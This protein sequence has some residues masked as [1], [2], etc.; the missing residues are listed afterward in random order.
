M[1]NRIKTILHVTCSR[2]GIF[3][4]FPSCAILSSSCY[5]FCPLNYL[6]HRYTSMHHVQCII[7]C[8]PVAL[9]IVASITLPAM[10]AFTFLHTH[11][12]SMHPVKFN[13]VL[14]HYVSVP[15][16]HVQCIRSHFTLRA[17]LLCFV[18]ILPS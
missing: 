2:T 16:I 13:F 5:T 1:C 15:A 8:H 17:L 3:V 11:C 7:L 10:L 6:S 12:T 14:H 9:L 18:H 4:H